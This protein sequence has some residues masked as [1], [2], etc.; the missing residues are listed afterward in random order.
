MTSAERFRAWRTSLGQSQ[1]ECAQALGVSQTLVSSIE[2][3]DAV[4][5]KL[6]LAAKIE[7]MSA[8]WDQGPIRAG[9]W[10]A[11]VGQHS[12]NVATIEPAREVA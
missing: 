5:T 2:R 12:E 3:G 11:A 7:S 8:T 10:I 6:A 1:L 9:E 4:V